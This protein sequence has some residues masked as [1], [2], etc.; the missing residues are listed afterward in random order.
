LINKWDYINEKLLFSKLIEIT[1]KIVERIKIS[2]SIESEYDYELRDCAMW[3]LNIVN[4][5]ISREYGNN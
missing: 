4:E 3:I 5:I 2:S 1:K